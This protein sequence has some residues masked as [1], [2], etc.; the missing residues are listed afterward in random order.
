MGVIV[1]RTDA[2]DEAMLEALGFNAF[3][4]DLA[5]VVHEMAAADADEAVLDALGFNAFARELVETVQE[6]A[7]ADADDEA[8]LDALGALSRELAESVLQDTEAADTEGLDN[9]PWNSRKSSSR[10]SR[11]R[12]P[13][14]LPWRPLGSMLLPSSSETSAPG[15]RRRSWTS[16]TTSRS[17]VQSIGPWKS[18]VRKPAVRQEEPPCQDM[19]L[20]VDRAPDRKKLFLDEF[21]RVGLLTYG[22]RS[23]TKSRSARRS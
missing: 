23:R 22:V 13:R 17:P 20:A 6:M 8:A 4:R 7:A 19:L 11:W 15:M 1:A 18:S 5:E 12:K 21:D 3:A 2:A 10:R 14:K 9:T 16:W